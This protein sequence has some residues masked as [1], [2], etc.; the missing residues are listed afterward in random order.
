MSAMKKAHF[1]TNSANYDLTTVYYEDKIIL[2]ICDFDRILLMNGCCCCVFAL[3]FLWITFQSLP[4]YSKHTIWR[5]N[6]LPDAM[7]NKC[8]SFRQAGIN[9]ELYSRR[10]ADIYLH[11]RWFI[12]ISQQWPA[13]SLLWNKPWQGDA[14]PRHR[15]VLHRPEGVSFRTMTR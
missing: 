3:Y 4:V 10:I 5:V 2:H 13:R 1:Q 7:S 15:G 12:V 9:M 14:A 11:N 8:K 6:L